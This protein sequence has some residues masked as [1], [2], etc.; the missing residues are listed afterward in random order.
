M[1]GVWGWEINLWKAVS[2]GSDDCY[3]FL[4]CLKWF[5]WIVLFHGELKWCV[6]VFY[7]VRVLPYIRARSCVLYDSEI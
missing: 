7:T 4:V 6:M 2:V 3:G 1:R 5:D